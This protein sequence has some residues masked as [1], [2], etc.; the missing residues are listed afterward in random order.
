[1]EPMLDE[2]REVAQGLTFE[3][4]QVPI[5]SNLTGE[6]A[7]VTDPGHWVRHVREAVRFMDGVRWLEGQGVTRF[8]ELCPDR[9]LRALAHRSL[10]RHALAVP[11]MRRQRPEP[12]ALI[13]FL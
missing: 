8:L 11:A 9:G 4:P 2:F 6:P 10:E 3:Q 1:M 12:E 13:E 7:D 5:V